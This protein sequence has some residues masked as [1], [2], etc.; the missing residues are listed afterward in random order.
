MFLAAALLIAGSSLSAQEAPAEIR[1]L[2]KITVLNPG[3]SYEAR[4]APYRSLRGHAFLGLSASYSYSSTFGSD[5]SFS[6]APA[7][8]VQFRNYYNA[9]RRAEAGKRTVDNNLNYVGVLTQITWSEENVNDDLFTDVQDRTR[10]VGAVGVVW[11][12]QRNYPKHFSLDLNFGPGYY[13]TRSYESTS[14][15]V[16]SVAD[17]GFTIVG[18]LTLGFWLN[19]K[20]KSED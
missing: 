8:G 7:F 15:G 9:R 11:G 2:T 10:P 3:I 17:N 4:L 14:T 5:Y 19:G 6:A 13:F 1:N 18:E 16:R 20:K 12:I